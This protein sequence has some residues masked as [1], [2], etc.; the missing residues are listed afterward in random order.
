MRVSKPTFK[1]LNSLFSSKTL[2][3]NL[4]EIFFPYKETKVIV[5]Y[6]YHNQSTWFKASDK[7]FEN[8]LCQRKNVGFFV[9]KN[10]QEELCEKKFKAKID[11]SVFSI[12]INHY[13]NSRFTNS[14]ILESI[15][16]SAHF[17]HFCIS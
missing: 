2:H 5:I 8:F 3:Q 16:L 13:N 15:F 6:P 1:R 10:F 12:S 11:D 9:L 14:D 17:V 4:A 7:K